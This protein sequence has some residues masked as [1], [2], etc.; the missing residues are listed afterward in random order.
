MSIQYT[1]DTTADDSDKTFT[2]PTG[3][4]WRLDWLHVLYVSTATVGNRQLEVKI[5]DASDVLRIDFHAGTTQ[6]ASLTRHYV[7]QPGIFRETAFVDNEIQ[8]AIPMNMILPAGWKIRIYDSA[9][10]DAAA[11]DMTVSFQVTEHA[12]N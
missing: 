12:I 7:F 8:I 4:T 6:A 1:Y 11:D 9:A 2:V 10:V 5:T 3:K